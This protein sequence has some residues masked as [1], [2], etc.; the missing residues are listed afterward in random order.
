MDNYKKWP[1]ITLIVLS[2]IILIGMFLPWVVASGYKQ[3][4]T[5]NV[6]N[7]YFDPTKWVL[8]AGIVVN[9]VLATISLVSKKD[10]VCK[11]FGVISIIMSV[12]MLGIVGMICL[13]QSQIDSYASSYGVQESFGVGFYLSTIAILATFVFSIVSLSAKK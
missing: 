5:I 10:G 1:R 2:L 3:T 4:D 8:L 7:T 12:A 11:T 9:I 13:W 6:F